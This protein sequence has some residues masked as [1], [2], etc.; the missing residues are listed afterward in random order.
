MLQV[1]DSVLFRSEFTNLGQTGLA[2]YL[3]FLF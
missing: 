1:E 3:C 2:L